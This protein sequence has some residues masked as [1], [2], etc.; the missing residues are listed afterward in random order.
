A[1]SNLPAWQVSHYYLPAWG[2]GG[3]TYDDALPPPPMTLQITAGAMDPAT[4]ASFAELGQWSRRR[5][6]SQGMG[7][8]SDAPQRVWELHL[9]RGGAEAALP[10]SALAESVPATLGALAGLAGAAAGQ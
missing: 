2:G 3:G 6:A 1:G 9:K 4:G 7:H 10:E 5:H 8:W